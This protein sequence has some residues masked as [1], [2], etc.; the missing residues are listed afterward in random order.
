M[1]EEIA[2]L[3]HK[4]KPAMEKLL[5][6]IESDFTEGIL[7]A[8][9][10]AMSLVF[11]ISN[12]YRKNI[13]NFNGSYL[14]K[15]RDNSFQVSAVFSNGKMIVSKSN[16][17]HPSITIFFKNP[18]ALMNF[19]FSPK[20]DILNSML[21]QDVTLDGNLNYLYKFAYM[22]NHLKIMAKELTG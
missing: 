14:F 11:I 13:E 15:G 18:S 22:A 9:L 1:L 19:I 20:P 2:N 12:S 6:G 17:D 16:I 4:A 7:E 3:S 21:R 5:K 10:E 8:L